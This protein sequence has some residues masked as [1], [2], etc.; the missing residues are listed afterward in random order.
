MRIRAATNPVVLWRAAIFVC[1][2]EGLACFPNSFG[3]LETMLGGEGFGVFSGVVMHG[4]EVVVDVAAGEGEF[5]GLIR[6]GTGCGAA[7]TEPVDAHE[8]EG[9]H[10]AAAF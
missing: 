1:E 2:V 5:W 7:F 3:H 9:L 6:G 4:I 10:V 8:A